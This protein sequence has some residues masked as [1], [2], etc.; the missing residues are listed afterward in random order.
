MDRI[1]GI[2]RMAGIGRIGRMGRMGGIGRIG[3]IG[4]MGGIGGIGKIGGIG[5]IYYPPVDVI[6]DRGE[7]FVMRQFGLPIERSSLHTSA[8]LSTSEDLVVHPGDVKVS[9]ES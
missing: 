3:R 5:R 6:S 7:V 1:G 9:S 2:G 8:L 4:G